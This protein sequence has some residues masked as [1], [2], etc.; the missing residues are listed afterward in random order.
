MADSGKELFNFSLE[1]REGE[2][3]RGNKIQRALEYSF[4][5]YFDSD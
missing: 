1:E 2:N 3:Q 4:I 5:L